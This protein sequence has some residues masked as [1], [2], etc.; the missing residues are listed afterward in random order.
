MKYN[1]PFYLQ[2]YSYKFY[3]TDILM[4]VENEFTGV[5]LVIIKGWKQCKCSSMRLVFKNTITYSHK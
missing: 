4:Y 3:S 5:L 2:F 1:T